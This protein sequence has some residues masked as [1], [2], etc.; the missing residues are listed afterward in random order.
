MFIFYLV[1]YVFVEVRHV[2]M[3]GHWALVIILEVLLQSHGVM[4]N[5]QH[6]VK[7]VGEHLHNR[8]RR[9]KELSRQLGGFISAIRISS[10]EHAN[11]HKAER[12]RTDFCY[13]P[14]FFCPLRARG[15][16]D[17]VG[18]KKKK[19]IVESHKSIADMIF[20]MVPRFCI[21]D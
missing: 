19:L 10:H 7:V 18:Q 2:A 13:F 21:T 16:G 15:R 8:Q 9:Y 20:F 3:I 11:P 6:S 5:V 4:W 17:T 12:V 14:G 1:Q